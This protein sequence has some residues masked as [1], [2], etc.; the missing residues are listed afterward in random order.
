MLQPY[1]CIVESYFR[2]EL[3]GPVYVIG[4]ILH[5]VL[6]DKGHVRVHFAVGQKL[7]GPVPVKHP[8]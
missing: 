2:S 3:D 1:P 7:V 8:S 4:K 5:F 6:V